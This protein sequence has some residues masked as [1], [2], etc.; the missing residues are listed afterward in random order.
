MATSGRYSHSIFFDITKLKEFYNKEATFFNKP[1]HIPAI[2]DRSYLKTKIERLLERITEREALV[3]LMCMIELMIERKKLLLKA[4]DK[5][6]SNYQNAINNGDDPSKMADHKALQEH[7][8]W[9]HS[10]LKLNEASLEIAL[11]QMQIIY[12]EVY[13]GISMSATKKKSQ[14]CKDVQDRETMILQ[15]KKGDIPWVQAMDEFA[16]DIGQD[17]ATRLISN[18]PSTTDAYT[19]AMLSSAGGVLL[20]LDLITNA[21]SDNRQSLWEQRNCLKS[22]SGSKSSKAL[23]FNQLNLLEPAHMGLPSEASDLLQARDSAFQ[24]L[25]DSVNMFSAEIAQHSEVRKV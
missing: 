5:C 21:L 25:V 20:T 2:S 3:K 22:T 6:H 10:N 23:L 13:T 18:K 7:Y 8:S 12:G 15:N 11:A 19:A 16:L 14:T 9:L 17:M 24:A 4:I 1:I